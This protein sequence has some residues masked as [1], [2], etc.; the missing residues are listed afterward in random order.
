MSLPEF[1]IG[2]TVTFRAYADQNIKAVVREVV[3]PNQGLS[4]D[5]Y[6]YRVEGVHQPLVSVTSGVSLVES[7][8]FKCPIN[9]PFNWQ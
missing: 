7:V 3:A 5:K 8:L 9:H 1:K 6:T 2:D 4:G